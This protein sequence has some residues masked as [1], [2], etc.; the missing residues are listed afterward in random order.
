MLYSYGSFL[1][2]ITL[3]IVHNGS[4]SLCV[5][6]FIKSREKRCIIKPNKFLTNG[7]V[8]M[9]RKLFNEIFTNTKAL[10]ISKKDILLVP[11]LG[12]VVYFL[13]S[14]MNT[15][16]NIT[17]VGDFNVWGTSFLVSAFLFMIFDLTLNKI[18]FF[19]K[20][21][22]LTLAISFFVST[23]VG[24]SISYTFKDN[25]QWW[26]WIVY[27]LMSI[28]FF[29]ALLVCMGIGASLGKEKAN[30]KMKKATRE[31][32]QSLK[33]MPKENRDL[34]IQM[35]NKA[36]SLD[37]ALLSFIMMFDSKEQIKE[38]RDDLKTISKN[39]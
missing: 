31:Y 1:S 9:L 37:D 19:N 34:F 30:E 26:H 25:I 33:E 11:L 27:A 35:S 5:Y 14:I 18:P 38:M 22:K 13:Q 12:A 3:S 32:V 15:N 23:F 17:W 24:E 8:N 4:C 16:F 28:I 20:Y 10:I 21:N 7:G 39:G 29:G 6:K 2:K 36:L